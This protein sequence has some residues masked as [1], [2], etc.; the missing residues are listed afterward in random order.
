MQPRIDEATIGSQS[1]VTAPITE[2]MI[3]S[4]IQALR[5]DVGTPSRSVSTTTF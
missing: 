5:V 1:R 3:A 2:T 4:A